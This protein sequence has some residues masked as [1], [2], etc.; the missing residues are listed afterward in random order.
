MSG[1]DECYMQ[2][3]AAS[4]AATLLRKRAIPSNSLA[5]I[6]KQYP[7]RPAQQV[8]S[9]NIHALCSWRDQTAR[10]EDEGNLPVACL[11]SPDHATH[12]LRANQDP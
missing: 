2:A 1:D 5:H 12:Q 6:S 11:C 10:E 4:A 8:V 9:D 3:A 7:D